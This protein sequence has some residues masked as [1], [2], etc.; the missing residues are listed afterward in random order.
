MKPALMIVSTRLVIMVLI[1]T[2]AY[3]AGCKVVI[4]PHAATK[5]AIITWFIM[6]KLVFSVEYISL[7]LHN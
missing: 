1:T 3:D 6:M 4:R 2:S 5:P 7:G